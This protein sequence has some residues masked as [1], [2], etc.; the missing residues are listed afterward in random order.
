MLSMNMADDILQE[1][2][3]NIYDEYGIE[4][5]PITCQRCD[6]SFNNISNLHH[7][8][9]GDVGYVNCPESPIRCYICSNIYPR[10]NCRD[11]KCDTCC[12]YENIC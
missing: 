1:K 8:M 10:K 12:V 4:L 9:R 2:C 11:N 7:H 3:K 6:M 5:L